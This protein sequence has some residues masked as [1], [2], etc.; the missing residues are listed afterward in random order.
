MEG[1]NV[2][3]NT[4]RLRF[5]SLPGDL[6]NAISFNLGAN[7]DGNGYIDGNWSSGSVAHNFTDGFVTT[8]KG[9]NPGVTQIRGWGE[10]N[11]FWVHLSNAGLISERISTIPGDMT[12]NESQMDQYFPKLSNG[13]S[14]LQIF[15]WNSKTYIRTGGT[16]TDNYSVPYNM[17]GALSGMQ[18]FAI[19]NK[20][21]N[22][23]IIISPLFGPG[24]VY[25][26]AMERNQKVIP[27]SVFSS[28]PN[29]N[30]LYLW[31]PPNQYDNGGQGKCVD[32]SVVP[33]RFN[34]SGSANCNILWQMDGF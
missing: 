25:P 12:I 11:R 21:G 7:G 26:L 20:R 17:T 1:Y 13:R 9:T 22:A 23:E 27:L 8:I 34:Q 30:E 14:Y 15:V 24:A 19:M 5:L 16:R 29:G 32:D 4:F 18:T 33:M 28:S 10:A 6:P 2:A 31:S 3:A